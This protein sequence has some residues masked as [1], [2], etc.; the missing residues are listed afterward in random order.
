[1]STIKITGEDTVM[2]VNEFEW[3]LFSHILFILKNLCGGGIQLIIY[4]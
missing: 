2:G 1:M 4:L 3:F